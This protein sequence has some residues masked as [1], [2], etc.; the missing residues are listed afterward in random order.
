MVTQLRDVS[1]E[2]TIPGTGFTKAHQLFRETVRE[3]VD[4]EI[5]PHVDEWEEAGIFPAHEVFKKL[6]DLGFL[7]LTKPFEYGGQGLDYSFALV[8]AE[9]LGGIACGGVP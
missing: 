1:T 2:G 7:G 8:M 9:E 3:F 5:N 4:R 6:G